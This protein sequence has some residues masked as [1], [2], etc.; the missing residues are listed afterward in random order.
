M[1]K[2]KLSHKP[3]AFIREALDDLKLCEKSKKYEVDMGTWHHP[4][5][6]VCLVCLAGA[7]MAKTFNC[8]PKITSSPFGFSGPAIKTKTK[9]QLESLDMFREGKVCQGLNRLSWDDS[10]PDSKYC[11]V[12][13]NFTKFTALNR[14][15][16]EYDVD[17]KLFHKDMRKLARDL[18]KAGY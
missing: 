7:V 18:E 2:K 9:Y 6:S 17:P 14:E 13:S 11:E 5:K 3:S 15:I 16:V 8:D 10:Y 4:V 1:K 12:H